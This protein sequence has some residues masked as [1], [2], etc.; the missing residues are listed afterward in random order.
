MKHD[1]GKNTY[2][3]ATFLL[4][5]ILLMALLCLSGC[6]ASSESQSAEGDVQ[7]GQSKQ[8]AQAADNGQTRIIVATDLHYLAE[9]L[10]TAP[11]KVK[12]TCE[13]SDGKLTEYSPQIV[14]TFCNQVIDEAPDALVLAGDL[15]FNGEIVSLRDL[16]KALKKVEK[17]G[18]P[19]LVI[20]G[21]HDIESRYAYSFKPGEIAPANNISR[22]DFR[23]IMERF[24]YSEAVSRDKDSFSYASDVGDHVRLIFLDVNGDSRPDHRQGTLTD[25]AMQWLETQ[26]K[27]AADSGRTVIT[28]SHQNLL[29]QNDFL[30]EGFVMD[31]GKKIAS[32]L[33][34]YG[35]RCHLS[36]HSHLQNQA[37]K[38]FH[39]KKDNAV[40]ETS[41]D[42]ADKETASDQ[43]LQDQI[44]DI[45][46]GVLTGCTLNYGLLTVEENG[47]FHYE[48]Q[49]VN[50]PEL[51]ELALTRGEKC[52]RDQIN[53]LLEM[54]DSFSAKERKQMADFAVKVNLDYFSGDLTAEKIFSYLKD[55]ALKLWM[56]EV[57]QDDYWT[58]Y[59]HSMLH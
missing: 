40:N 41:A 25:G 17:A 1:T 30:Y 6:A 53:G 47:D 54:Y 52:A 15:T 4:F 57:L 5:L 19:V 27:D 18:I 31:N 39:A 50:D 14:E 13:A 43:P 7:I 10:M 46:T 33:H 11:E 35:V 59:I 36:G 55:P 24:G 8:N 48:I 22:T 38:K 44:T 3:A 34:E 21:N 58:Q 16:Q 32:L 49:H 20:P 28:V 9:S 45:C 12:A 26:L 51:Q 56:D 2:R 23:L 42:T 37:V 29:R